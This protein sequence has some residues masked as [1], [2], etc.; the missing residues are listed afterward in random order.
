MDLRTGLSPEAL[1]LA[2]GRLYYAKGEDGTEYPCAI[3]ISG[4]DFAKSSN[5]SQDTPL[6][7]II[8]NSGHIS[9]AESLI[10]YIFGQ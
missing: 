1:A 8:A 10:R 7:G 6:L 4:T 9:T 5:L 2:D 3:D